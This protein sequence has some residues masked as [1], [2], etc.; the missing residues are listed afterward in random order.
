MEIVFHNQRIS[1]TLIFGHCVFVEYFSSGVIHISFRF[2]KNDRERRFETAITQC[3]TNHPES[4]FSNLKVQIFVGIEH[5]ERKV[6]IGLYSRRNGNA[7]WRMALNRPGL[8]YI[9]RR[10][11]G[12]LID[13]TRM[14]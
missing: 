9:E 5:F 8:V 10:I 14:L 11:R 1:D 6:H 12:N 13:V 4:K 7:Y 3:E 2:C